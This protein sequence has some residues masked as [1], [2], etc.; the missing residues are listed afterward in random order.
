[1]GGAGRQKKPENTSTSIFA[2]YML[3]TYITLR[4]ADHP[5]M[6]THQKMKEKKHHFF[7]I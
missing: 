1:M 5:H 6:I 4:F 7:L 3:D 2:L